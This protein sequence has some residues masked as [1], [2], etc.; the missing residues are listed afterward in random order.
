VW[1]VLNSKA[2]PNR[3]T[4][5][6]RTDEADFDKVKLGWNFTEVPPPHPQWPARERRKVYDTSQP[7]RSNAGHTYGDKLSDAERMAVIEYLK[8]L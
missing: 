2:R 1:H 8:T 4:R 6:Y 3:F 7:G 5:S